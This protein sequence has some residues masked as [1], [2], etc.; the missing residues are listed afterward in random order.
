MHMMRVKEIELRLNYI[1]LGIYNTFSVPSV[2]PIA[3]KML[4]SYNL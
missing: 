3:R 4:Q 1:D 2:F